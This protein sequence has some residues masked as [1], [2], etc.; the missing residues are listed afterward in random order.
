MDTSKNE[1]PEPQST[2][3]ES[4]PTPIQQVIKKEAKTHWTVLEPKI[5]AMK[6]LENF[7]L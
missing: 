7:L 3:I 5:R 1:Q 2:P 6:V 4:A